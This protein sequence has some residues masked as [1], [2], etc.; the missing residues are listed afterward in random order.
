MIKNFLILFLGLAGISACIP[1]PAGYRWYYV[2]RGDTLYSISRKYR[3]NVFTLISENNIKNPSLIYP[4]TRLKIPVKKKHL[5]KHVNQKKS[6]K[7]LPKNVK[8]IWPV[9]GKIVR[10]FGKDHMKRYIGVVLKTDEKV[11]KASA[12]GKVSF[13]GPV[14]E[15]GNTIILKHPSGYHTVY[16]FVKDFFVKNGEMVVQGQKIASVASDGRVYFEIRHKT[17]PYNPVL[18]CD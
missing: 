15:Y 16:G 6:G 8:F 7:K 5:K 13:L 4:G 3:V 1:P 12:T 9:K 17:K 10:K 18:F 2:R 11:I 14:G